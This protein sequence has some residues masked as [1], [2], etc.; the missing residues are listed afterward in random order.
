MY[1]QR[2]RCLLPNLRTYA[3]FNVQ[4]WCHMLFQRCFVGMFKHP[5]LIY[6]FHVLFHCVDTLHDLKQT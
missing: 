3:I 1:T 5:G 2:D 4:C 6:C